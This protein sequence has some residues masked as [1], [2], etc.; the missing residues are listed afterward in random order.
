MV[1]LDHFGLTDAGKVRQNNEDALL[2]GEGRDPALFAVA[3]GIGGFEA[4]EVASSMVVE[5]LKSLDSGG[6]LPE[7]IQEANRRIYSAASTDEK[8]AGMGT[9]IVAVRLKDSGGMTEAEVSHVGDSRLYLLRDGEM[10][11]LTE[12]HSLVAELVR[13]GS[14]TRAQASEHP[15]KNLIT[16]ALGAEEEVEV[17]SS[18]VE[19][20]PGDRLILCSDG[21]P[22]M[23]PEARISDLVSGGQD[24]EESTRKLVSAALSAGGTDNVT[25]VV[26]DVGGRGSTRPAAGNRTEDTDSAATGGAAG[27]TFTTEPPGAN[28]EDAEQ[29]SRRSARDRTNP[30]TG[31]QPQRPRHGRR[32]SR[33]IFSRRRGASGGR[34]RRAREDSPGAR[35]SESKE[36]ERN[37]SQG[38]DS[39][40]PG[41]WEGVGEEEEPE[42]REPTP[43]EVVEQFRVRTPERERDERQ[44]VRRRRWKR[45]AMG[46]R[47]V[48]TIVRGLAALALIAALLVPPYLWWSTRYYMAYDNEEI[49]I[50]Q[51]VPYDFLGNELNRLDRR[52]GVMESDISEPYRD[53][54]RDNR[55]YTED[56]LQ[57]VLDDLQEA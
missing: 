42:P 53:Q 15:Q 2:S 26:V 23:V 5:S 41:V 32:R 12:D 37:G 10:W 13:S 9:T 16:R 43:E 52:T 20:R 27:T 18:R 56:R 24:A 45:L 21:L 3:D 17:D 25:V 29:R 39:L 6:S 22:D 57:T 38:R 4:G 46:G 35:H 11:P 50:Y 30:E 54:I 49:V 28:G 36:P 33:G 51:G 31:A 34:S 14:L 40:I 47:F 55:L 7:A 8:L 19:I 1:S 48:S 44:P